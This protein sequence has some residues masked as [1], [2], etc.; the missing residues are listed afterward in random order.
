MPYAPTMPP[1]EPHAAPPNTARPARRGP[2]PPATTLRLDVAGRPTLGPGK[3]RLLELIGETGSIS[4]AGRAMGM[5]YRRAWTLVDS[6]NASFAPLVAAHPAESGPAPA[7]A[8]ARTAS[9]PVGLG[10][11]PRDGGRTAARS[12]HPMRAAR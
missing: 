2:A 11:Q 1:P 7:N 3:T 10:R 5:G 8:Q 4:V 12:S 9:E 6:L